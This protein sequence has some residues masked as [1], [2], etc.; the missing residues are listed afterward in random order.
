MAFWLARIRFTRLP[1]CGVDWREP[2]LDA[3]KS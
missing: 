2:K 1:D 3:H